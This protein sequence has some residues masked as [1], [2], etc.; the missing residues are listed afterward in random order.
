MISVIPKGRHWKFKFPKYCRNGVAYMVAFNETAIYNHGDKDQLD[1]NKLFG[2]KKK[3]FRPKQDSSMKAWRWNLEK[4]CVEITDYIH[5]D[6]ETFFEKEIT[7]VQLHEY[8]ELEVFGKGWLILNWFGG[9]KKAP[10]RI[11]IEMIRL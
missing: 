1:W 2:T 7:E 4:E 6:G 5:I 3:F 11:E 8:I 9:Q 10:H